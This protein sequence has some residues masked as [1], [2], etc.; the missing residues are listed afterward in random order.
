MAVLIVADGWTGPVSDVV[1]EGKVHVIRAI[2]R[3]VQRED[4]SKIGAIGRDEG[5]LA[6]LGRLDVERLRGCERPWCHFGS[7]TEYASDMFAPQLLVAELVQ[8]SGRIEGD[9]V[10]LVGYDRNRCGDRRAVQLLRKRVD[11]LRHVGPPGVR[12]RPISCQTD[13]MDGE[14]SVS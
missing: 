8:H 2:E 1:N 13:R 14:G 10:R 4:Q 3:I 7:V 6:I 11:E 5:H 9:A 12:D